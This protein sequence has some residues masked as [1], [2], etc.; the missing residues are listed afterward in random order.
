MKGAM[1]TVGA[2][3]DELRRLATVLHRAVDE[4]AWLRRRLDDAQDR[5]RVNRADT[6]ALARLAIWLADG[7]VDLRRRATRLEDG[8]LARGGLLD[9]FHPPGLTGGGCGSVQLP[10]LG[11][12]GEGGDRPRDTSL[13]APLFASAALS[14]M[15]PARVAEEGGLQLIVAPDG[16]LVLASRGRKRGGGAAGGGGGGAG[17]GAPRKPTKEEVLDKLRLPRGKVPFGFEPRKDWR[18]GNPL[19]WDAELK[20]Y[21]DQKKDVWRK[22]PSRTPG[23]PFEWD[24]QLKDGSGWSTSSKDGKHLNVNLDGRISH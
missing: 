10:V 11:R 20:G 21:I 24:V 2:R 9:D 13:G 18:P 19:P 22:G 17:G 8:W 15:P 1:P 7:A 6:R 14:C 23:Q 5:A 4:A 3:P 16:R 12:R